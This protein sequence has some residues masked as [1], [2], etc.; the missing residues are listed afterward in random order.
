MNTCPICGSTNLSQSF[1][2]KFVQVPFS[3]LVLY[4]EKT[5]TCLGCG[6]KG[7]FGKE[8]D[9]IIDQAMRMARKSSLPLMLER[10]RQEGLSDISLET[11]FGLPLGTI[12]T[13]E[14]GSP[15][16]VAFLQILLTY[17]EVVKDFPVRVWK[18]HR[19]DCLRRLIELTESFGGYD[20]ELDTS[21]KNQLVSCSGQSDPTRPR[22]E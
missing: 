14:E 20:L 12:K 3:E 15:L 13:W 22:S 1:K 19:R 21:Q 18:T 2:E 6:E 9:P 10:L 4:R 5:L 8:N 17:P 7:D 16:A 11:T